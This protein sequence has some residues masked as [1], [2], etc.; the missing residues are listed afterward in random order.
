MQIRK[1]TL[2][3]VFDI[4][5]VVQSS[6]KFSYRGYLPDDYLDNLCITEDILQK[7]Q[8][9]LQKYECYVAE[10]QKRIVAFMMLDTPS[11]EVFEIN[12][13]YVKPEYQKMGIGS[14][15]VDYACDIKKASGYKKCSVWTMKNGP[16][17]SFYRSLRFIFTGEEREWKF[18]LQIEHFCKDLY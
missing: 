6:Y 13:L 9:Y 2:D 3:D 16:A 8:G 14:Q 10:K 17:I 1:T 5:E 12:I 11:T 15:L 18:G 7:W 4:I